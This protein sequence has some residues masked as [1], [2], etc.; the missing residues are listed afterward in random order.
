MR[1]L[2]KLLQKMNLIK[3]KVIKKMKI[4]YQKSKIN[5]KNNQRL[6]RSTRNKFSKSILIKSGTALASKDLL[7]VI[8]LFK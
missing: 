4:P 6:W 1:V 7:L 2:I 3:M 5:W 8:Q